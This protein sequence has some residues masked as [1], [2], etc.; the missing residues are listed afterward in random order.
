MNSRAHISEQKL[1]RLYFDERMTQQ[2]IADYFE[3]GA[4]S[5]RRRMSEL[6]IDARSRGPQLGLKYSNPEWSPALAYAIGIIATD[7][8]LSSDGRHLVVRSKD[9]QLL[10]TLKACLGLENQITI[11]Q[12]LLH[13]YYSLQWGDRAFYDWLIR[14]GMMPAKSLKLGAV[15]IPN[16]F[17]AD[18]V[19]GV[20]DGDGSIQLY[21]DRSNTW[22]NEKYVYERLCITIASSSRPFLDWLHPAIQNEISARGAI[23][24]RMRLGRKPHWNLKFAKRD[25]VTVLN[26][27]YYGDDLPRLE[28][29]YQRAK[30]YLE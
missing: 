3:C 23:V 1:R 19:R 14:I 2:E 7:G 29:K 5:I 16:E 12:K 26:W 15:D 9:Y 10:E 18:F 25:S 17:L 20:I 4:T 8:N 11:R 13:K 6:G 24:K 21:N 22:K 27:I 28:R 30:P